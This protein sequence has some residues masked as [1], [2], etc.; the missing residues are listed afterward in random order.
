M[1][2]LTCLMRKK[3]KWTNKEN[4]KQEDADSLLDNISQTEFLYKLSKS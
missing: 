3:E 2:N 4:D 1:R